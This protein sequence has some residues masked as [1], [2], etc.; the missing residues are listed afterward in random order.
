MFR[1]RHKL[2]RPINLT[3][4]LLILVITC[5]VIFPTAVFQ[6]AK[7]GLKA[8]WEIVMPA[9]L[10]FFIS[11]ELLMGYGIVQFMGVLFEPVMRPLFN[12]PG[13]ASFVM[14]IGYTSGFPISASLTANLRKNALCTR[15]EAEKLVSFT[16]NA[17]PL[18]ML[19]AVG[20]GMLNNPRLGILIALCHYA[21]NICL[22]I[23]LRFYH[24][25]DP[26]TTTKIIKKHNIFREAAA[27]MRKAYR[28][29]PRPL[30]KMLGDAI[31]ASINKLLTIGGFMV[32]FSVIINLSNLLGVTGAIS[33]TAGLIMY[34]LGFTEAAVKSLSYG[35]FEITLGAKAASE[36]AAPLIQKLTVISMILGWSG[37]SVIAQVA[38]MVN[39]TD[40]KLGLFTLCR[41]VHALLSG[42]L[43]YLLMSQEFVVNWLAPSV[44]TDLPL[45]GLLLSGFLEHLFFYTRICI[46]TLM[47]WALLGILI[48]LFKS[49]SFYRMKI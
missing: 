28:Q 49:L 27:E 45:K 48:Y 31:G 35:F 26:E 38:A 11:S 25:H 47:G 17:S 30:G 14:A 8:W 43:A 46:L 10:P 34:K 20:V 24:T 13:S 39:A 32:V 3:I 42:V 19:V 44:S 7:A 9:L 40:I 15:Y 4:L 29:N 33:D 16:N 36:S 18:F 23:L 12:L 2:I 5:M 37:I 6:A 41:S 22:G 21:A 1:Q